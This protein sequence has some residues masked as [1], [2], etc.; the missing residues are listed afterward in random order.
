MPF[1]VLNRCIPSA[2]SMTINVHSFWTTLQNIEYNGHTFRNIAIIAFRL[3]VIPLSKAGAERFF[4]KLKHRYPE[5]R[6]R[7]NHDTILN[8]IHIENYHQ[9]KIKN[10]DDSSAIW[11]LPPHHTEE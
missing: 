3:S 4:S 5:R 2:M 7:A 1:E 11:V 8:E 9:N 10:S 6:N